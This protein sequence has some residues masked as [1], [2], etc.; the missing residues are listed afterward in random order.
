MMRLGS[1]A[2]FYQKLFYAH[3]IIFIDVDCTLIIVSALHTYIA[4]VVKKKSHTWK[5]KENIPLHSFYYYY[6]TLVVFLHFPLFTSYGS[7]LERDK[8]YP[9][10]PHP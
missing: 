3:H 7:R 1:N 10:T 8:K 5:G 4:V 9:L 2:F 6:S